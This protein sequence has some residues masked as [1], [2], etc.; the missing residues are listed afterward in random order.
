MELISLYNFMTAIVKVAASE[1]ETN[2]TS[3]VSL[4]VQG[5]KTDCCV[6][7]G[8][9][10]SRADNNT[11]ATAMKN[12]GA[13]ALQPPAQ[14]VVNKGPQQKAATEDELHANNITNG[15]IN[16]SS[17]KDG[18]FRPA[19]DNEHSYRYLFGQFGTYTNKF[20]ASDLFPIHV[21]RHPEKEILP[22][23]MMLV[24][25]GMLALFWQ[26]G[27]F[28]LRRMDNSSEL[29]VLNVPTA[30]SERDPILDHQANYTQQDSPPVYGAPY[31]S[32]NSVQG[33][34]SSAAAVSP[35]SIMSSP[36]APVPDSRS[37]SGRLGSLDTFRGYA[38]V[39]MIFV[40]YGGGKY[41]F[42]K[43]SRWNGL[44]V[45]D[46]VFPWFLWI[47]GVSLTF[48]I[49]SQLRRATKHY[50]MVAKIIKRCLI[51]FILGLVINSMTSEYDVGGRR[52]L[53]NITLFGSIVATKSVLEAQILKLQNRQ[54]IW[55]EPITQF[56]LSWLA[57][58]DSVVL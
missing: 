26:F 33:S 55:L 43:H 29:H 3:Q 57:I 50:I 34:P 41:Y 39:V 31:A 19:A 44:T 2:S 16:P 36:R 7:K 9:A 37:P 40:N 13:Q 35:S 53:G 8:E 20:N 18:Y 15:A 27:K 56:R 25:F 58:F 46:L 42:F 1:E 51:L 45:A 11:T 12:F 6:G 24:F 54:Q 22:I 30:S 49:R 4:M 48:S 23:V 14:C 52:F 47:M 5:M 21:D 10:S 28:L 17:A 32:P 38:I